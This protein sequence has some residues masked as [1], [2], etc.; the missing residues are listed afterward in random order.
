MTKIERFLIFKFYS[1]PQN[2]FAQ[3]LH[4]NDLHHTQS[5]SAFKTIKSL[6]NWYGI[7]TCEII[8]RSLNPPKHLLYSFLLVL[9]QVLVP[10]QYRQND[11]SLFRGQML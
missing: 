4:V 10:L 2:M 6:W 7:E 5:G 8:R 9:S 1:F 11:A 3:I